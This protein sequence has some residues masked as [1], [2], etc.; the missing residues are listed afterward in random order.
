VAIT[1][2][3]EPPTADPGETVTY[4]LD[5]SS[6]G[7]L[8][9]TGVLITDSVPT[10]LTN[11]SYTSSGAAITPTGSVPYAWEVEDLGP[12]TGGVITITGTINPGTSPGTLL[13]NTATIA[14]TTT[15]SNPDN[16]S[17]TAWV[18]IPS[19][20]VFLPLAIRDS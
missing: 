17:S 14:G 3:A 15:D 10:A 4:A 2:S 9:A 20:R 5:F 8:T 6:G 16:N 13:I 1:K 18:L 12:G 7:H 19:S 11:L